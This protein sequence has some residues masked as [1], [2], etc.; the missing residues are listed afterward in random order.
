MKQS[1]ISYYLVRSAWILLLVPIQACFGQETPDAYAD[2]DGAWNTPTIRH[3]NADYGY[4]S[5]GFAD[6][7]DLPPIPGL[8]YRSCT[9]PDNKYGYRAVI[10]YDEIEDILLIEKE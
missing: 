7:S 2:Y 1:L 10:P 8:K 9:V 3:S 5:F 6:A 4:L